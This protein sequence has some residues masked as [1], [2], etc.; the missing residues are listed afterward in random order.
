[1]KINC[2]QYSK[3]M[4]LLALRK[5]LEDGLMDEEELKRTRE[6]IEVL[7]KELELD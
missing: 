3:S 2:K 5:K 4:E 7:E 6:R 1:M